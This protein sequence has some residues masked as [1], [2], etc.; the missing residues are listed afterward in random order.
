MRI[1]EQK[2][3]SRNAC[4]KETDMKTRLDDELAEQVLGGL[5]VFHRR[6]GYVTYTHGDG[7]VTDHQ[8]LNY[9]K[10]WETCCMLEAQKWDGDRIFRELVGK[11]YL[12]G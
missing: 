8:V 10:A 1:K 4:G 2:E 9:E 7:T 11:G 6:S 5:F 12:Q 3:K